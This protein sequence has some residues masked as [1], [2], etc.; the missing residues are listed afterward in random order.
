[1]TIMKS[2]RE[3]YVE[4]LTIDKDLC[5]LILKH[6]HPFYKKLDFDIRCYNNVLN[7]TAWEI[8]DNR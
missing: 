3:V 7:K 2:N 1:M 6:S 8:I 4:G 5:K